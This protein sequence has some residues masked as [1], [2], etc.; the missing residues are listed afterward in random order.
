M[1]NPVDSPPDDDR[2]SNAEKFEVDVREELRRIASDIRGLSERREA[3]LKDVAALAER[4]KANQSNIDNGAYAA[5]VPE[6]PAWAVRE[7]HVLMCYA[8]PSERDRE[9]ELRGRWRTRISKSE[10][11]ASDEE[12]LLLHR[13]LYTR[14]E[15]AIA[16]DSGASAKAR[17]IEAA[18]E[19]WCALMRSIRA[20]MNAVGWTAFSL[21]VNDDLR[22]VSIG[23]A[24]PTN[25]PVRR[26]IL[27]F[28]RELRSTLG[29]RA[30]QSLRF[31]FDRMWN[32]GDI[33]GPF[34]VHLDEPLQDDVSLSASASAAEAPRV[35][36]RRTLGRSPRRKARAEK[37]PKR[38]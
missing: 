5:T 35:P 37:L 14:E 3:L 6:Q 33:E 18:H 10:R 16:R 21:S 8:T 23:Y 9:R 36:P 25:W 38:N 31:S 32:E 30:E 27:K 12:Q 26:G 17:M 4:T 22:H 15:V 1:S 24:A 2:Y 19:R 29:R 28:Q 13:T 7:A 34:V 20:A 11:I